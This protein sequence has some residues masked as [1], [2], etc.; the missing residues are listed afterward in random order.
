MAT[1]LNQFLAKLLGQYHEAFDDNSCNNPD[2][3]H[4][5]IKLRDLFNEFNREHSIFE[6]AAKVLGGGSIAAFPDIEPPAALMEV[7]ARSII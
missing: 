6:E 7:R 1:N 2:V 4:I 3:T 5:Y